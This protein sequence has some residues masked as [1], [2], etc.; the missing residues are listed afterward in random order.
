MAYMGGDFHT[1]QLS[2]VELFELV[3]TAFTKLTYHQGEF[4]KIAKVQFSLLTDAIDQDKKIAANFGKE[5]DL[6]A[7]RYEVSQDDVRILDDY[8]IKDMSIMC[9]SYISRVW[10]SWI[11]TATDQTEREMFVYFQ[12]LILLLQCISLAEYPD[13][14]TAEDSYQLEVSRDMVKNHEKFGMDVIMM[15]CITEASPD[16]NMLYVVYDAWVE[17]CLQRC[18][19]HFHENHTTEQWQRLLEKVWA[20]RVRASL[21]ITKVTTTYY[22]I[23][24]EDMRDNM[25]ITADTPMPEVAIDEE[26]PLE[27][28]SIML[29]WR[30]EIND[31]IRRNQMYGV[32]V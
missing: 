18:I 13:S 23:S 11:E 27:C 17:N 14:M 29:V 10:K 30:D 32:V 6:F 1:L 26:D 7:S 16:Y 22:N 20:L 3:L 2:M 24:E 4:I 21:I 31:I 15:G 28:R 5:M 19:P 8:Q 25:Y 9:F 12:Q